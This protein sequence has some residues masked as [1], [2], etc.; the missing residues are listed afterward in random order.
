MP[1]TDL[2]LN[3][4]RSEMMDYMRQTGIPIFYS[5]EGP[6][7]EDYTYWNARAFPD[8]RQFVDVAKESGTRM[9]M[10][11]YEMLLEGEL[12]HA[13]ER[14]ADCDMDA[15]D[16]SDYLRKFE[17]LRRHV[18][19]TTWVRIAFEYGGRWLAYELAAAWYD[20]FQEALDDLEAFLPLMDEED[21]DS[22]RG[23]FSRN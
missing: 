3:R 2:D 5:A 14:L 10:F 9:L 11:S 6:D 19:E 15:S 8:W 23:F 16:R 7:D 18:G 4:L 22:D 21:E 13:L 12:E 17:S 1:Q 20:E